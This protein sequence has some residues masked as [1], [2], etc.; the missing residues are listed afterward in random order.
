TLVT[1]ADT[2]NFTRAAER[3]GITQP[4]VSTQIKELESI[5]GAQLFSRNG[6]RVA[7]T[8]AGRAFQDRATLTLEKF[9]D[10]CQAVQDTEDL[11]AGHLSLG[12]IPPLNVPWMPRVLGRLYREH[13]GIA[14]TLIEDSADDLEGNVENGRCDLGIG[15]LSHSSPNLKYE[16]LRKDELVLLSAPDGPFARKRSVKAEDVGKERIVV[17]PETYV[18]R[19]LT[20]EVFRAARVLPRVALEIDTIDALLATVVSSGLSTLLPRVVLEG[21]EG[22]GLRPVKLDGWGTQLDL[23]IVWPSEGA[24]SGPAHAFAEILRE[25]LAQ[26]KKRRGPKTKG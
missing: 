8:P 23:G 22:L 16:V 11:T 20:S 25:Q 5:L 7:L 9:S 19:Q 26:K 2:E 4:S 14:V 18:L 24:I 17:L 6:P 15:I 10:A 1:V 21:R 13:P 12:V 3:L